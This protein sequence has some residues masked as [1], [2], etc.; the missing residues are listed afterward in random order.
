MAE[1]DPPVGEDLDFA[2]VAYDE[3][4]EWHLQR[5]PQDALTGVDAIARELRRY[6]GDHGAIALIS[7]D[8]DFIVLVRV[9][10]TQVDVLLSDAT[11][12]TDW[13]LARSVMTHLGLPVEDDDEQAPAGDLGL[14]ADLGMPAMDMGVLLDDY[15]LYPDELLST[16]ARR[17]GFGAG[18]DDLVGTSAS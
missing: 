6:P 7:V 13:E 15:D 16:I 2:V 8:E 1:F 17:A 12:A 14:L 10:G 3:E 4:G 11:A 5:F 9:R 18:F